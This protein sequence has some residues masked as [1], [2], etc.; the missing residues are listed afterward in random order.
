MQRAMLLAAL[1]YFILIFGL[2][3]LLGAVR[4]LLTQPL[5]GA[6]GALILEL[7][8]M[9]LASLVVAQQSLAMYKVEG[10]LRALAMGLIAFALLMASE[11]AL[12]LLTEGRDPMRWAVGLVRWPN[13]L[14]FAAQIAFGLIPPIAALTRKSRFR[15]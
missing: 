1:R 8:L 10:L 7:P 3:I 13:V 5:M 4:V 12:Y 6:T 15:L 14:G 9:L 11:A 2:G